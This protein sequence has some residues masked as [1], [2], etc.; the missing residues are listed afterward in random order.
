MRVRRWAAVAAYAILIF[1]VSSVP[2]DSM[3]TP[4]LPGIDKA[5]HLVEYFILAA[6]LYRALKAHAVA[7]VMLLT[8]IIATAYGITDEFHQRYV[9]GRTVSAADVAADAAGAAAFA[10]AALFTKRSTPRQPRQ[11]R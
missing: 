1:A 8:V 3:K 7:H 9:P 5:A 6:L 2:S 11:G 4:A 10:A